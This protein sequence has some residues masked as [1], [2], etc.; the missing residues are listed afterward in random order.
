MDCGQWTVDC[1]LWTVD[2]ELWT[3][4]C[5]QPVA[6]GDFELSG[7]AGGGGCILPY[8]GGFCIT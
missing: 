7:V 3:V 1:G 2:G 5:G 6:W 4:D 8:T